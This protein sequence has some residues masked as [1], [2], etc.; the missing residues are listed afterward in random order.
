MLRIRCNL[1]RKRN[2]VE[3][4]C[5][6][7]KPNDL[8]KIGVP[9]DIDKLEVTAAETKATYAQI[10]AYVKMKFGLEVSRLY[11]AQVKRKYNLI[12]LENHNLGKEGHKPT[13]RWL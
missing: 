7:S 9:I 1:L 5:L 8:P 2:D 6:L 12:E 11:I 10:H 4:V 13:S 3:T